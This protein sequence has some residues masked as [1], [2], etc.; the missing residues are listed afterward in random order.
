MG[1]TDAIEC[2][3][4]VVG[5][6]PAGIAAAAEAARY[7]VRV[8]L[9]DENPHVGGQIFRPR[10]LPTSVLA[11]PIERINRAKR[12]LLDELEPFRVVIQSETTVWGA[13]GDLLLCESRGT[14]FP[15]RWRRLVVA[16]GAVERM[17]P[18]PGWTLPGVIT[19]GG[20]QILAK[21]HVQFARQV[22][23]AGSGPFLV[24]AALE[25]A[26]IGIEVI[27]VIEA[28]TVTWLTSRL[29]TL[30][31]YG[32]AFRDAIGYLRALRS[33]RIPYRFGRAVVRIL[34]ESRVG[35]AVT[36]RVD[37]QWHPIPGTEET[38]EV[39]GVCLGYGFVPGTDLTRLLGC[40]HRYDR[41]RGGWVAVHDTQM[42]TSVPGVFVAGE[43]T[44]IGGAAVA[45]DEGRL[46]GSAAAR[47]LGTG[48][49]PYAERSDLAAR[50]SRVRH[51][52][53]TDLL[54]S[55]F[56][57]RQGI[58]DVMTSDTVLCRCEEATAGDVR[59]FVTDA[60]G[61][62]RFMRIMARTGMG[63]CQGRICGPIVRDLLWQELLQTT[64]LPTEPAARM[65]IK[66]I[67]LTVLAEGLTS[68]PASG[69]VAE[70][71]KTDQPRGRPVPGSDRK[72]A[73][74]VIV[75]A[76]V[77]GSSIACFLA[78][79]GLRPLLVE[80]GSLCAE[81]SGSNAGFVGVLGGSPDPTLAL[82]QSSMQWLDRL[83]AELD[84]GFELV[85]RGRLVLAMSPQELSELEAAA[86][87]W[88]RAGVSVR[89]LTP[90][91][92]VGLEP[93]LSESA[94]TGAMYGPDDGHLNPFLLTH[95]LAVTARRLGATIRTQVEALDLVVSKS[96]IAGVQT[97][98][99]DVVTEHVVLANGAWAGEFAAKVGIRLM[100][101]PGRGQMLITEPLRPMTQLV[102]QG[103]G[104]GM[105]QTMS[106]N[107]ML[108]SSVEYV[109][110]DK[111]VTPLVGV[112]AE[113]WLRVMPSLKP[114]QVIRT[115]AGLRPMTPDGVPHIGA[116]PQISGL[117]VA[118]GHGRYGLTW[119]GITGQIIA[120]LV[121][122]RPAPPGL[123]AVS[124][125]REFHRGPESVGQ[126]EG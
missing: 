39:D 38:L 83:S 5:A 25:L 64:F 66:P 98:E 71:P 23:V 32:S 9:L 102:I 113:R 13:M 50:R 8:L 80:K 69:P 1:S 45:I 77:I 43:V 15:V 79:G 14:A 86:V 89:M 115:W 120:D 35:G 17:V 76:G 30:P 59:P 16:T 100:V 75:G 110:F 49:R 20:A 97:T 68:L 53:F 47:S 33:H 95:A 41:M 29:W 65:P 90:E 51:R 7:G 81:A 70:R 107:L 54:L 118:A 105:R 58:Y 103:A 55:G 48:T 92:A 31:R 94:I 60:H 11:G 40:E 28:H 74:V 37:G 99:G 62:L 121:L 22:L 12:H 34:G 114:A 109:G 111:T 21:S 6:G 93:L 96:R 61:D 56:P 91:E 106:G 72:T 2:D 116:L 36:A 117:Y 4:L 119:S 19:A 27:A 88:A 46:A 57:F 73:D 42:E 125:V 10:A 108:G 52:A 123:D 84:H 63:L 82:R 124:P 44:G 26:A 3:V 87:R 101:R 122:G 24:S 85:K 78:Q 104:L 18:C 126:V 112:F 67:P